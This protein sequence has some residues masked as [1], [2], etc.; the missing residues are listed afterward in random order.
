[1][2]TFRRADSRTA[3]TDRGFE[4]IRTGTQKQSALSF[5][6]EVVFPAAKKQF[7][8]SFGEEVVHSAAREA[9]ISV[10]DSPAAFAQTSLS[11]RETPSRE[12][13]WPLPTKSRTKKRANGQ[14]G[15]KRDMEREVLLPEAGSHAD[16]GGTPS[17]EVGAV[18]RWIESTKV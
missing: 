13:S 1:M 5:G 18:A 17:Q 6:Q 16:S 12:L 9:R 8:L 4:H 7:T 11:L 10:F 2:S 14:A 15:D 3:T